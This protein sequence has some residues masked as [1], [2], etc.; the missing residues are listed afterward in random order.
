MQDFL[1]SDIGKRALLTRGGK[2]EIAGMT[3]AHWGANIGGVGR[4]LHVAPQVT[5]VGG[6][7]RGS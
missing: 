6:G 1:F 5:S 7:L 4:G 3:V 2:L